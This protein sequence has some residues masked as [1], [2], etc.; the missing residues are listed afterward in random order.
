[1]NNNNY[2]YDIAMQAAARVFGGV[3]SFGA[4]F[5]LTYLFSEEQI[6][7][8]NLVLS[9]VN[10]IASMGT[11]W[12]SQSILRF[13]EK[14]DFGFVIILTAVSSIICVVCFSIYAV[15]SSE[16]VNGWTFLYVITLVI[17]NV[18]DA[19]FRKARKLFYYVLLELLLA[20]GRI[21]PMFIIGMYTKN[22]NAVFESQTTVLCVYI[23]VLVL[24][25]R[26][27]FKEASYKISRSQVM[28]YL[29]FGVPLMG[30]SISNWFL[31]MS[32]R[33]I[34]SY[35]DGNA[36]VGIYSTNYSLANSIYTM[37]SLVI[38]NAYHPIIMKKWDESKSLTMKIVSTAIEQYLILMIPLTVY[39]CMKSSTV[40]GLFQG[41]LYAENNWIFNWVA[42]GILVQGLSLLFHKYY[43][44]T[45]KT[46]KILTFNII[47]AVLNI[48]LNIVLIPVLG[49]GVAAFT[50]FVAYLV[51]CIIVRICTR[52]KFVLSF[53]LKKLFLPVISS[54]LFLIG[55]KIIV[56]NDGIVT[57]FVE[58]FIFVVYTLIIYQI[59]GVF[60][61]KKLI[62]LK[63]D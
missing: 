57:F 63:N 11:L 13:Y 32:D 15:I 14:K 43:E 20:I 6:G 21:F 26:T 60:D 24:V 18:F 4:I 5:L 49:F 59:L 29:Q 53:D 31:T 40:L 52:K 34:I 23:A 12:L 28:Q 50:T 17:Y 36:N 2:G 30:L 51:Y 33:Y 7:Q 35:F 39:G 10:I 22:Y 48:T 58:G 25:N 61:L 62:R 46:S 56:N 44:L 3:F 8:Y 55:D 41:D 16:L 9:T 47:V 42:I 38:I 37:F 1:M 45:Q 54:T 19:V 27:V